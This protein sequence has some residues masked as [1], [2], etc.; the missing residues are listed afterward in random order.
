[1]GCVL[2][3]GGTELSD[4]GATKWV[5]GVADGAAAVAVAAYGAVQVGMNV[6]P[7]ESQ[8]VPTTY[9]SV[10]DSHLV[11]DRDTCTMEEAEQALEEAP[12]GPKYQFE[13]A[14][15]QGGDWAELGLDEKPG[16]ESIGEPV[17]PDPKELVNTLDDLCDAE[18]DDLDDAEF[19][20]PGDNEDYSESGDA[21]DGGEMGSMFG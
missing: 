17:E 3:L 10:T 14:V 6:V 4:K 5:K 2:D 16:A 7:P 21:F 9:R 11:V 13:T 20:D 19:D 8:D 12:L 1:M 18:F 15:E